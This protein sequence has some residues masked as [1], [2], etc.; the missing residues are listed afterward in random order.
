[1][2]FKLVLFGGSL[3]FLLFSIDMMQVKDQ[4]NRDIYEEQV[5]KH[6]LHINSELFGRY[7]M[8]DLKENSWTQMLN[9]VSFSH[10]QLHNVPSNLCVL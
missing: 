3:L 9:L 7:V 2:I 1:M 4:G 5:K 10:A 6:G 8:L